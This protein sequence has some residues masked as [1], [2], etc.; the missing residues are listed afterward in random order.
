MKIE[1]QKKAKDELQKQLTYCFREFEYLTTIRFQEN[2]DKQ[3]N[4]LKAFPYMGK[5]EPLLWGRSYEY[6]SWVVHEHFKLI[7]HIREDVIYIANFWNV[8]R[9][10]QSL[11]QETK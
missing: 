2:L 7:Y 9:E 6:R 3:V 5:I 11:I 10:P 8:R 4:L 1:W